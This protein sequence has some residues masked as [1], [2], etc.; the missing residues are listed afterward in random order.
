MDIKINLTD[1]EKRDLAYLKDIGSG[2]IVPFLEE[3]FENYLE[4]SEDAGP[5]LATN[6]Y[7]LNAIIRLLRAL[8][9]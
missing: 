5:K 1:E 9:R 2:Q 6:Y 3:A 7:T 4:L 8:D